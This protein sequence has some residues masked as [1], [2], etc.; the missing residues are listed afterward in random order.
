MDAQ[1]KILAII[2]TA[3][4]GTDAVRLTLPLW[5]NMKRTIYRF[6]KDREITH[7][8]SGGAPFAD[9]LAVGLFNAGHVS[10][11]TLALPC[12]FNWEKAEFVAGHEPL[13]PAGRLNQLHAQFSRVIGKESR[14][15]IKTAIYGNGHASAEVVQGHGF[16]ARNDIVAERADEV[17]AFT[18]GNGPELSD[19][20]TAYTGREY[21]KRG[22]NALWHVDLYTMDLYE[23]GTVA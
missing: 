22:K 13:D 14:Q 15:E 11:L 1:S 3:G 9:H 23:D 7:V 4:R 8:I 6:I 21:L 10:T 2:G 18:F 5:N 17:I 20:G 19:G 16:H 12:S